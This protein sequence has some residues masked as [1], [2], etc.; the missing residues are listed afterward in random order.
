VLA[1]DWESPEVNASIAD[2]VGLTDE[3]SGSSDCRSLDPA[4]AA[5]RLPRLH[6]DPPGRM[7][8]AQAQCGELTIATRDA[9][10]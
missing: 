8:V 1:D 10:V 4:M 5:G 3:T 7:L 9:S 2:D 6:R